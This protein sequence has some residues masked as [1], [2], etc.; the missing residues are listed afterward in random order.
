MADWR[1]LLDPHVLEEARTRIAN[2]KVVG[3]TGAGIS[4][5]S[6]IPDFR[7]DAGLWQRY[8]PMEYASIDGFRRNPAKVWRFFREAEQLV[9]RAE[10]NR[11]HHALASL[12]AGDR[13]VGVITQNFDGLHER[14]GVR[15]VVPY[16]GAFDS[17]HCIWCGARY[18]S[19]AV[20]PDDDGV[21]YCQC[22]RALKPAVVLFGEAIPEDA[23]RASAQLIEEADTMLIVGT[24]GS[25]EPASTI[26]R[27][28][29][30][31]GGRVIEIGLRPPDPALDTTRLLLRGPAVDLLPMLLPVAT[32]RPA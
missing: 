17:L 1:D 25:V 23:V 16:H 18:A 19:S 31:R 9:L 26:P 2:T 14:S 3:F 6:G 4:V 8:D 22:G 13:L 5:A 15:R 11:A 21:P 20:V 12:D 10:P 7:S 30:R 29:A 28:F 32:T 27:D 24:S